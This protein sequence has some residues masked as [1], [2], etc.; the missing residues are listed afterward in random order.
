MRIKIKIHLDS[1]IK[2]DLRTVTID[3]PPQEGFIFN[4]ILIFVIIIYIINKD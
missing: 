2:V 1:L 4:L 3:I